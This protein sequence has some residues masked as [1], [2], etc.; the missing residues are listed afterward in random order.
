MFSIFVIIIQ[1]LKEFF[2]L[3][4]PSSHFLFFLTTEHENIAIGI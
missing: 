1:C 2:S 4:Q 3:I